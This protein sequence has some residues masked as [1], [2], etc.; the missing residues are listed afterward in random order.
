MVPEHTE[1][2]ASSVKIIK[3]LPSQKIHGN[4]Q[5]TPNGRQTL[6]RSVYSYDIGHLNLGPSHTFSHPRLRCD[7]FWI[8]IAI[9]DHLLATGSSDAVVLLASS[10]PVEWCKGAV[11]LKGGHSREVSDVSFTFEGGEVC[12]IGEDMLARVWRDGTG[13]LRDEGEMGCGWGWAEMT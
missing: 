12:S 7:T 4:P 1:S 10:N 5:R 2:R 3:S 9:K 11:V 6:I 8:K 13:R